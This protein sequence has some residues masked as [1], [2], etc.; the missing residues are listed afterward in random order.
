MFA[1]TGTHSRLD[2]VEIRVTFSGTDAAA[3]I[4]ALAPDHGG[5]RRHV[6]FC[7]ALARSPYTPGTLARSRTTPGPLP[8]LDAGVTLRL[9]AGGG[10]GGGGDVTAVLSPCR[11]SRLT[12]RW[13]DFRTDGPDSLRLCGDWSGESRLFAAS[14]ASDCGRTAVEA[15]TSGASEPAALFSGRQ[16]AFLA[17]CADVRVDAGDLTVLGP[18]H[19]ARWTGVRLDH[20]EVRLERWTV[21][22]S[23]PL[24]WFEI[25][26]RVAPEGAEVVQASLTALLRAQGLEPD[27]TQG[28][29]TR[30]VLEA[31]VGR[32]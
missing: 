32:R 22:G 10:R 19:A 8:L 20:H 31:L 26:E 24:T 2:S 11:T 16:R 7:E 4:R 14:F 9:R 3:A 18:V 21:R 29:R 28:T 1:P 6:H 17:D 12:E 13:L 27:L 23:E 25:S 15:V 30:R 5:A